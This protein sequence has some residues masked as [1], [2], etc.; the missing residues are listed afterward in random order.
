MDK[1]EA[2][3]ILEK[4]KAYM[5][6]HGGDRQSKSLEMAIKALEIQGKLEDMVKVLESNLSLENNTVELTEYEKYKY[7]AH[8]QCLM[9]LKDILESK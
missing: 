1:N 8:Y 4:E 2:I 9:H 5:D 7:Q 6:G 3:K